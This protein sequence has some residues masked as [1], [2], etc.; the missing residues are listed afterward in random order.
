MPGTPVDEEK[1]KSI[2]T[3]RKRAQ[4]WHEEQ[5]EKK[6]KK[7]NDQ[8][9]IEK[10]KGT[11][12]IDKRKSL[13][14]DST[15]KPITKRNARKSTSDLKNTNL[16]EE[17]EVDD[18]EE[19][20]EKT[21]L[22]KKT[23][24][25]KIYGESPVVIVSSS[26]SHKVEIVDA[27][28]TVKNRGLSK[29]AVEID[30]HDGLPK[31]KPRGTPSKNV[32]RKIV[33]DEHEDEVRPFSDEVKIKSPIVPKE[34]AS[35]FRST[36]TEEPEPVEQS[37]SSNAELNATTTTTTISTTPKTLSQLLSTANQIIVPA[38]I[39]SV[40]GVILFFLLSTDE[41]P[42]VS[43]LNL[44][45]PSASPS[46]SPSSY[47]TSSNSL[48]SFKIFEPV[49]AI[50]NVTLQIFL[51]AAIGVAVGVLSYILFSGIQ[52]ILI[53][54]QRQ[55]RMIRKL[56]DHTKA[57]LKDLHQTGAY[58][59]A[60]VREEVLDQVEAIP[61]SIT[62]ETPVDHWL[63]RLVWS[64]SSSSSSS[65]GSGDQAHVGSDADSGL[66]AREVAS[67]LW[68]L[69]ERKVSGDVRVQTCNTIYEGKNHRCW[70]FLGVVGS[71]S[72]KPQA[73]P[74]SSK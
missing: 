63:L 7:L 13:V 9:D 71:C 51:Y 56:C 42:V 26:R 8:D 10:P 23:R 62:E 18:D 55:N 12:P 59:I 52:L 50:L 38:V 61:S 57:T 22:V 60:F 45:S 49:K 24:S 48:L 53:F 74:G 36:E 41:L 14:T 33:R 21:N 64:S 16:A 37:S 67:T 4:K 6:A 73:S 69:V 31:A 5:L 39:V 19:E 44:P 66:A 11:R 70:R 1:Q 29:R 46:L 65:S 43:F 58:P 28:N 40:F 25:D 17:D 68:P 30:S 35:P 47:P 32:I 2:L 15:A 54:R 20:L 27:N 72:G 3:Q 34:W